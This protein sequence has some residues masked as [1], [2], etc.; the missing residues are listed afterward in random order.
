MK[1]YTIDTGYFKLDGGPMFGVVPKTM[2]QKLN[3]PDEN[4]MCTWAMRCL[5]VEDQNRRM[6]I[7]TGMGDFI[8]D[9]YRKRYLPNGEDTLEKSLAKHGFSAEDITDVFLTHLHF[10][11]CMGALKDDGMGQPTLRFPNAT[12]WS[13]Y[14]QWESAMHPNAR[15]KASYR[16]EYLQAIADSGKLKYVEKEELGLDN[17]SIEYTFGHTESMMICHIYKGNQ[18]ISYCADLVPSHHH[19]RLAYIMAYDIRPM[20]SLKEKTI[21]LEKAL[22]NNHILFFEHDKDVECATL[23]RTDKGIEVDR[24]MT[25]AEALQ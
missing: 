11:H 4:N 23:K 21:F 20:E 22:E 12:Y 5:L 13:S 6:L 15:E 1:L 10:D 7:D 24:L 14:A 19:V 9:T 8:D 3:P 2:W 18:T 16:K 25:L 17:V